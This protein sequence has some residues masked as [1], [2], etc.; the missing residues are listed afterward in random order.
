MVKDFLLIG[1]SNV[2]RNYT[3]L[4]YQVA[5]VTVVSAKNM[6]E[7]KQAVSEA[8]NESF[9]LIV[10]ACITN[11]IVSAGEGGV[12]TQEKLNSINEVINT[13]VVLIRYH[14]SLNPL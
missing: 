2:T 11:L 8:I 3:R 12:S 13:F 9:K 14:P 6:T 10:F 7:V 5:N 1:D 4:G